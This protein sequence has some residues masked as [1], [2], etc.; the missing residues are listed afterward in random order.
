MGLVVQL[1]GVLVGEGLPA[2]LAGQRRVRRVHLLHVVA[3]V[4]L[5]PALR[6][7]Q[8]ATVHR[9]L[10]HVMNKLVCL[11]RVGLCEGHVAVFTL[12]GLLAGVDA[13][14]AFQFE[15]VR[16][17]VSAVRAL[18]GPLAGVT[19]YVSPQ[20]GQFHRGVVALSALV[21]LFMRVLVADMPHQLTRSGEWTFAIFADMRFH[22]IV[23][24][25]VVLEGGESLETPFAYIALMWP[26]F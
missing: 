5:A 23:H 6:R 24:V 12:V 20:F 21:R 16:R 22:T 10:R 17:R 19:A 8:L 1:A 7:A 14:M 18:V 9:L 26:F 2:A 11:E 4:R 15:R 25:Q 3:Q 13:Q